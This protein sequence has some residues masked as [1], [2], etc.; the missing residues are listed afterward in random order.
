MSCVKWV[1]LGVAC[2]LA[3]TSI[4]GAHVQAIGLVQSRV[5][6]PH[7]YPNADMGVYRDNG[8]VRQVVRR[9]A[10]ISVASVNQTNVRPDAGGATVD[11]KSAAFAEVTL[12]DVY[13]ATNARNFD[14][15][16]WS[17]VR[18][19]RPLVS[20]ECTAEVYSSARPYL[21]GV[22][23]AP[24]CTVAEGLNESTGGVDNDYS[25]SET[26]FSVNRSVSGVG[27]R[28]VYDSKRP[29]EASAAGP[30]PPLVS[31]PP[32]T[33]PACTG[34][35]WIVTVR[36]LQRRQTGFPVRA[37]RRLLDNPCTLLVTLGT[38]LPRAY[39]GW[40]AVR[41]QRATSLHGIAYLAAHTAAP[42]LLYDPEAWPWTPRAEQMNPVAAVCRAAALA[43]ARGKT[44]IATPAVDLVQADEPGR[45]TGATRYQGFERTG[46]IGAMARCADG[47]SIQSQVAEM[48]IPRYKRFVLRAVRQARAANPHVWVFSGLSTNPGGR[49]VT[50]QQL[51]RAAQAVGS[52][53]TGFWLNIPAAGRFCPRCG[54]AHPRRAYRLLQSM[55]SGTKALGS[56]RECRSGCASPSKSAAG[57]T[58]ESSVVWLFGASGLAKFARAAG[59]RALLSG[60]LNQR[61]TWVAGKGPDVPGRVTHVETTTNIARLA[62]MPEGISVLVD[63]ENWPLTPRW[64]RQHP[65]EA[66]RKAAQLAHRRHLTIIATPAT[67]LVHSV[68]PLYHGN[69]YW[70]FVKLHLASRIAPYAPIYEI[71]AQNS[72]ANPIA[73]R[74][75]VADIAAQVRSVNPGAKLL[76]GLTTNPFG[77]PESVAVL[78]R[79]IEMTR[80]IVSGYWLNI[81]QAGRGCPRCGRARP[82]I[83][84]RLL[85]RYFGG[86]ASVVT[87]VP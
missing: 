48:D 80:G 34:P 53:V 52:A 23:E 28:S 13:S 6:L 26:K 56:T 54:I 76:A 33:L 46:W 25:F 43:H 11:N 58:E 9:H 79:D 21:D 7:G 73:Y 64:Q 70:E 20:A 5:T 12:D 35:H 87:S 14:Y 78:Y 1:G 18:A 37:Q 40:R 22:G 31:R 10:A 57:R 84:V 27:S 75:F 45:W 86:S 65:V 63:I 19:T 51:R 74:R 71:Q 67:D 29:V 62:A 77:R 69:M 41:V 49:A 85:R 68:R 36:S 72:E 81:P 50:P 82:E 15:S 4:S 55:W 17:T 47:I 44:L 61:T 8:F 3:L 24:A 83:A 66:Y 39:R 16:E 42:V 32:F 60:P 2:V 59:G 38:R 30:T